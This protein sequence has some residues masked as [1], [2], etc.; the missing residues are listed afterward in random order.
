M[1]SA[2]NRYFY[3]PAEYPPLQKST[4]AQNQAARSHPGAP[5]KN[6]D[7]EEPFPAR[8]A[9]SRIKRPTSPFTTLRQFELNRSYE[10]KGVGYST[11]PAGL[12]STGT[13]KPGVLCLTDGMDLCLGVAVGGTKSSESKVRVFH[14]MPENSRAQWKIGDYV[15]NLQSDGYEV[16]AALHGG[17]DTSRS[18][19]QKVSAV[20][21]VLS[22]LDVPIDINETGGG[23]ERNGPLGAVVNNDGSF[24]FVRELIRPPR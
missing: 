22:A 14:V 9:S 17:D 20:E 12:A 10:I 3:N 4:S 2:I 5:L 16:R 7:N 11:T 13:S 19:M 18:S 21:T 15:K 1:T 24:K 23:S 6:R 8:L